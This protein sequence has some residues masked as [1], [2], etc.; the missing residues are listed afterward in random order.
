MAMN[1]DVL[2]MLSP[3]LSVFGAGG[4]AWI[5]LK[6]ALNGTRDRVEKIER[7]T[8]RMEIAL[9]GVDSRLL[10]LEARHTLLVDEVKAHPGTCPLRHRDDQG[11]FRSM[12]E[13]KDG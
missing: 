4:G 1:Q 9:H 10:V 3:V 6:V 8:G 11:R 7:S 5:A 2:L 12:K 13:G